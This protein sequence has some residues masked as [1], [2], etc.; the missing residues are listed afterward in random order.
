[1]L[2]YEQNFSVMCLSRQPGNNEKSCEKAARVSPSGLASD[3]WLSCAGSGELAPRVKFWVGNGI[4]LQ[5][6]PAQWPALQWRS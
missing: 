5:L 1:V 6:M 3:A 4:R 2:A